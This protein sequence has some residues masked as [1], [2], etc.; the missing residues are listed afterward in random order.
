MSW[1]TREVISTDEARSLGLDHDLRGAIIFASPTRRSI[2][3][4]GGH[5]VGF[6]K[7]KDGWRVVPYY[8]YM[9]GN[10]QRGKDSES[11]PYEEWKR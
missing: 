10:F 8:P 9:A 7:R 4:D 3:V 6:I 11:I 2:I 5:P 1:G